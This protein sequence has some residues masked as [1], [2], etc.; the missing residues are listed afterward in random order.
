MRGRDWELLYMWAVEP[1]EF[2]QTVASM[3]AQVE[4][5]LRGAA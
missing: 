3:I 4:D 2:D 1:S 5:M